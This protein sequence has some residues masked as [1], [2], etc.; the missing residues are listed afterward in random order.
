MPRLR[1]TVIDETS[2]R[3]RLKRDRLQTLLERV[4]AEARI[5]SAS[6]TVL[7]VDERASARL[8]REH[9]GDPTV[10]DVMSFPDGTP[11]DRRGRL[12]LGDLAVCVAVARRQAA[13]H[14]MA[15]SEELTL[16]ILHGLLHLVGYDDHG[17]RDLERMWAAQRRLLATVGIALAR[18]PG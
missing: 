18:T 17:A 4:L 14:G 8:H 16:Y 5:A 13:G 9:F 10:T 15:L 1:L 2:P 3:V 7:L 6:L 11:A 12:H